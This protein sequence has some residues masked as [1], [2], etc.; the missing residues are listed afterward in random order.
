M[1]ILGLGV[2]MTVL[3]LTFAIA[4]MR[5][6]SA[7]ERRLAELGEATTPEELAKT[8]EAEER[9]GSPFLNRLSEIVTPLSGNIEKRQG[10]AY[11]N[12][13]KRL[14]EAGLRGPNTLTAYLG[15]RV[16]LSILLALLVVVGSWMTRNNPSVILVSVAA[17]VGYIAPGMMVDSRIRKRRDEIRDGLADAIDMMVVCVESGLALVPTLQR[18]A[19]ELQSTSPTIAEEFETTVRETE[20][21]RGLMDSLRGMAIRTGSKE[22]SLFVSLLVQTDRFGTPVVDMLT[23]QAE[24]MRFERMQRAEA[25][26][27]KAPVRMMLPSSMI[28]MAIVLVLAGPPFLML[29]KGLQR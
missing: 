7:A 22:L 13:R 23:T 11:D 28:F 19:S 9:L 16:A 10:K 24:A 21:G 14:V 15:G 27:Q 25:E 8:T 18:V 2:T 29:L 12:L 26:A 20:A 4:G 5:Q 6:G 3:F 1:L 17:M